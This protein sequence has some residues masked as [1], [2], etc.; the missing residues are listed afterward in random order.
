MVSSRSF[1]PLVMSAFDSICSSSHPPPSIGTLQSWLKTQNAY[2]HPGIDIV[3]DES[4]GL[5]VV[6]RDEVEQGALC[7]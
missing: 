6:A 5:H 1:N 3:H 4:F 2:V 7:E